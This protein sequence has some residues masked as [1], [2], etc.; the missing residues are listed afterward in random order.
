MKLTDEEM[1]RLTPM[2]IEAL[3]N[4]DD[5]YDDGLPEGAAEAAAAA[6]EAAAAAAEELEEQE[7]AAAAAA[8]ANPLADPAPA[9][10]AE[11]P[12]EPAP[13]ADPEPVATYVPQMPVLDIKAPEDAQEQLAAISVEKAELA[14]KLEEGE[15][16]TAE[17]MQQL[18]AANE[19]ARSIHEALSKADISKELRQQQ[20]VNEWQA[21]VTRFL[22]KHKADYPADSMRLR[23]LDECVKSVAKTAEGLTGDQIMQKAHELMQKEFG[24][25]SAAPK[26]A[27]AP[28]AK[29]AVEIPPTL[30]RLPAAEINLDVNSKFAR[31]DK[32]FETNP[33]AYEAEVKKLSDA[34][35]DEYS[36]AS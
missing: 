16:S 15:V 28:A 11:A 12:A 23:A 30:G 9:P 1:A 21:S 7:A 26:P 22:D 19:R 17:F 29:P 3:E 35:R 14:R 24:I 36:R 18:D 32:L 20:E 4:N 25:A 31:L 33:L 8:A 27:A 6:A 10:A 34:E 5:H 2:E 13:A